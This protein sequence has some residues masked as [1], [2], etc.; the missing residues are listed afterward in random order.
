MY[1]IVSSRFLAATHPVAQIV[2]ISSSRQEHLQRSNYSTTRVRLPRHPTNQH[3]VFSPC[4][5]SPRCVFLLPPRP[6]SSRSI[7][8]LFL[9]LPASPA[10]IRLGQLDDVGACAAPPNESTTCILTPQ[11]SHLPTA[12]PLF[13]PSFVVGPFVDTSLEPGGE[14]ILAARGEHPACRCVVQ[15]LALTLLAAGIP[16]LSSLH[17]SSC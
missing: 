10:E 1:A 2:L 11:S 13:D 7:A 5:V 15:V 9:L 17:M 16:P 6:V 14:V 3:K 4:T 8:N 12:T